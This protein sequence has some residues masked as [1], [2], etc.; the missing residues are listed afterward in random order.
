MAA[1]FFATTR[2]DSTIDGDLFVLGGDNIVTEVDYSSGAC[3]IY[4]RDEIMKRPTMGGGMCGKEDLPVL[5]C[6]SG[7]DYVD[8]LYNNGPKKVL[9]LLLRYSRLESLEEKEDFIITLQNKSKWKKDGKPPAEG[10]YSGAFWKA[11]YLQVHAPVFHLNQT[12][13]SSGVDLMNEDSYYVTLEPLNPLPPMTTQKEWGSLIGFGCDPSSL[14]NADP[15]KIF[16]MQCWG[17]NELQPQE[18]P[19]PKLRCEPFY[20]VYHGAYLDEHI[21]TLLQSK[22]ALVQYLSMRNILP[23]GKYKHRLCVQIADKCLRLDQDRAP[24]PRKFDPRVLVGITP[25]KNH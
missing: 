11:F 14:F 20:D 1:H 13:S 2:I 12:E 4:R 15:K 19:L 18:L 16:C 22:W 5:A 23:R 17:E 10:F 9:S 25:M 6:F 3:C 7:N 24:K 21:P 8:R